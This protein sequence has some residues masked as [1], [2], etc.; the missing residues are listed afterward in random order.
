LIIHK[1]PENFNQHLIDN[2]F[3]PL[4]DEEKF[5]LF[6]KIKKNHMIK[7]YLLIDNFTKIFESAGLAS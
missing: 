1:K 4:N 5:N 3:C 2:K 7:K 6:D